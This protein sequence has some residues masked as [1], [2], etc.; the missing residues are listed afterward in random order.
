MKKKEAKALSLEVWTYRAEHPELDNKHDLPP[1]LWEKI[2]G[3]KGFCPLCELFRNSGSLCQDC[4]LNKAGERCAALGSAYN[5]WETSKFSDAKTS[6]EAAGRIV[7]IISA[8]E[9]EE[10]SI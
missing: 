10:A 4:P 2:A 1:A 6:G 7:K 3:L 5:R 9:P 8:W